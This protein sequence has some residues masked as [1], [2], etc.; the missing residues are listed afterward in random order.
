MEV[1]SYTHRYV[2]PEVMMKRS[3]WKWQIESNIENLI[4]KVTFTDN[5]VVILNWLTTTAFI[6]WEQLTDR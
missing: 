4:P 3:K 5:Q 2:E 6:F 1:I